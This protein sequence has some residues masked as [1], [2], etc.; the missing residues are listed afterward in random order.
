[1][2][3][4]VGVIASIAY[5]EQRD[6]G[7]SAIDARHLFATNLTRLGLRRGA[8]LRGYAFEFIRHFAP[9]LTRAVVEQA[10]APMAA[11]DFEI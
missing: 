1:L 7:L 2:G 11:S 5:D 8:Y 4:G 9:P 6:S 10:M 3:M